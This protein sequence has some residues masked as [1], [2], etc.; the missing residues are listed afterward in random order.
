MKNIKILLL[1]VRG[2]SKSK[3][4]LNINTYGNILI[5][6]LFN[7]LYNTSFEDVLC[8]VKILEKIYLPT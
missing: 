6:Y 1:L 2:E 5:N 3:D 7:L 8:C 4:N